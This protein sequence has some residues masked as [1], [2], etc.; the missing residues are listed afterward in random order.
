MHYARA[1]ILAGLLWLTATSTLAAQ[2]LNPTLPA[3]KP[4]ALLQTAAS[5]AADP[6]R[7]AAPGSVS[8][9]TSD[10]SAVPSS[11]AP[12]PS[13]IS[14]PGSPAVPPVTLAE[15]PGP[16]STLEEPETPVVGGLTQEICDWSSEDWYEVCP[17]STVASL[18]ASEAEPFSD[19]VA[20]TTPL[21]DAVFK[22][23]NSDR[24][25]HG[26]AP[27]RFEPEL[28]EVAR[29]RAAAQV[30][31]SSLNHYD[32]A[33]RLGFVVLLQ[34]ANMRY[35]LAGENLARVGG[36]EASRADRAEAALMNS[37]THRANILE[38]SFEAFAVGTAVDSRGNSTF[39]QIFVD[40]P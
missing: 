25:R 2:E 28:L 31:Q 1:M 18:V 30:D 17:E 6:Y 40:L 39:A 23:A 5:P 21:E 9:P 11:P 29:Q 33:G 26:L 3:P 20:I 34:E 4:S 36:A 19:A 12:S 8:G 14:V 37:P 13:T 7:V 35:R 16:I 24:A 10:S 22:L 27:L 32:G 38:P 15:P